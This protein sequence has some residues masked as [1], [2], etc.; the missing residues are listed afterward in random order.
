MSKE[1]I[2]SRLGMGGMNISYENIRNAVIGYKEAS[3]VMEWKYGS[4][5]TRS[6]LNSINMLGYTTI[7]DNHDLAK[8]IWSK[9]LAVEYGNTGN[10]YGNYTVGENKIVLSENLL[11]GGRE[12]SAK[13]ATVMSHEGSHY[14]GNR[15]EAIAHLFG[16]ETYSQINQTISSLQEDSSFRSEML[17][18]IFNPESWKENTGDV[19]HWKMT[20][21][22]QLINDG[23]GWLI[24]EN[25]MYINID[26]TKSEKPIVGKTLG[27][28]K[29][30]ENGNP[31]VGATGNIETGLLNII[32]N[33]SNNAYSSFTDE[34][35]KAAQDLLI[36]AGMTP[37]NPD[38]DFKDY[39]WS[40]NGKGQK[41]DMYDFMET[42]GENVAEIIFERYYNNTVDSQI[43][44]L[45]NVNLGFD[46]GKRIPSNQYFN[47]SKMM[48]ERFMEYGETGNAKQALF[49][50]YFQTFVNNKN[51]TTTLYRLDTENPFLDKL[52]GQ[53][54]FKGEKGSAE[55]TIDKWG[56][57]FM[58]Q[59]AVPQL[60]TGNI[61]ST[62]T[63]L[64]I[65]NSS[66]SNGYVTGGTGELAGN[67]NNPEGLAN[68]SFNYAHISNYGMSVGHSPWWDKIPHTNI[69]I[70]MNVGGHFVLGNLNNSINYNPG[71]NGS[72]PYKYYNEVMLYEK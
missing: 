6:T 46:T 3:K 41:L 70:V 64:S 14:N 58:S 52:L 50:K 15:V 72:L 31:I 7:L 56:C 65:W 63:V 55:Y 38:A 35:I 1:G 42:A 39:N 25:G 67:V 68:L 61:F 18:A 34:Q 71:Y 47:Y 49:D 9:K 29:L 51:E 43:S 2:S 66:I 24:D 4:T 33:T 40:S 54:D 62:D 10:D 12:A 17:R 48:I 19:D 11:G 53:H 23:Q 22:G 45:L 16:L 27:A 37:S 57:N 28:G 59:L 30:D 44:K 69:A 32:A 5:E 20:W 21:G 60:M 36:G 26:G 8:D 13:L